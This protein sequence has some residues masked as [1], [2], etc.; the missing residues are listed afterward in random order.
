MENLH[1]ALIAACCDTYCDQT[2]THY[3]CGIHV[4]WLK[5]YNL[6]IPGFLE[7]LD[8]CKEFPSSDFVLMAVQRDPELLARKPVFKIFDHVGQTQGI[9]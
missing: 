2:L 1:Q 3:L 4:Y 7:F 5:R 6:V 8:Y 9:T